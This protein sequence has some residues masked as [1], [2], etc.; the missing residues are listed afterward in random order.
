MPSDKPN[1]DTPNAPTSEPFNKYV[2]IPVALC[3][4]RIVG[5]FGMVALALAD[6]TQWFLVL[7]FVL[8]GTDWL[9][10]K[11][12]VWL[13]QRSEFGA[14]LDS[15]AD[16]VM[17]A[18]LLFGGYWWKAAALREEWLLIGLA[19][20]S[21]LASGGA[22]LIKFGRL[23]SYHTRSAK[24][25]WLLMLIAVVPLILQDVRWPMRA[26]LIVVTIANIEGVIITCM[27]ND[28]RANVPSCW[29]ARNLQNSL[30]QSR[31]ANGEAEASRKSS[32]TR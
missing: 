30:N 9:D 11:L 19:L 29:H 32:E 24:T 14:R 22:G 16:A 5:A 7:F 4:V 13:D 12:A 18:A 25:S 27:L 31:D 6:R 15:A 26:A 8:M 23:P 1:Q 3:I 2:T 21:Y 17:Y 10:G 20:G 28:W